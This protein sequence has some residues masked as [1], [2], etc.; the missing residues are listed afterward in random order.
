MLRPDALFFLSAACIICSSSIT[1]VSGVP[2]EAPADK[3]Y[4][5][6][7]IG[8]G[9]AGTYAAVRLHDQGKSVAVIERN[10]YL[11]GGTRTYTDPATNTTIDY[12]VQIYV[13]TTIVRD[14]FARFNISLSSRFLIS[15][16]ETRYAD[17]RTGSL[18]DK[19]QPPTPAEQA[20]AFERYVEQL[21]RF[22]YLAE[23]YYLPD[24]I[25]AD[26]TSPFGDFVKKYNLGATVYLIRLFSEGF[27]DI[28]E[29]PTLYVLRYFGAYAVD[30]I[31]NNAYIA[32]SSR[33]NSVLF[34]RALELLKP[35][36]FLN[37]TVTFASRPANGPADLLL[38]TPSGS[39]KIRAKK[40][41]V[42]YPQV[43][44]NFKGWDLDSNESSVF[45]KFQATS[46]HNGIMRNT[47]VPD[48]TTLQNVA[49]ETA[50]N[51]PILP[52]VYFFGPSEVPG[53][54]NAYYGTS[55]VVDDST[56]RRDILGTLDRLR[57]SETVP[58]GGQG[59]FVV[60][61]DNG[62]YALRVSVAELRRGFYK[63]LYG[64]QGRRNTFYTGAALQRHEI[65]GIWAYTES[66]VAN[67]TAA[68]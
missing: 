20:E 6:A 64:L 49:P 60:L 35:S 58:A 38:A 39:A 66:L 29:L 10:D 22:P 16:G 63:K 59:D 62:P 44:S 47:G 50:F 40:I 43:K 8:G 52:S 2:A 24:D 61:A 4:D 5:V 37:S 31:F 45:S 55:K 57:N 41:V 27:G 36:V 1:G 30:S 9:A 33:N 15:A 17:F 11:G 19:Y 68:L 18:V 67:I 3:V 46:W 32:P 12:G 21:K 25:P 26:L 51:L 48:N 56:A 34:T 7:V 13:N 42:A 65:S 28:L 53:L 54:L 14:F 23:G